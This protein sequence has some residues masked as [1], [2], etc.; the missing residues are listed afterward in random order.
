[1]TESGAGWPSTERVSPSRKESALARRYA[2]LLFGLGVVIAVQGMLQAATG[3]GKLY[4]LR[5]TSI[6]GLFGPYY[7]RDH[8]AN[9]FLMAMA[10]G[11][12]VL[13]SKMRGWAEV[14]GPSSE[15]SRELVRLAVGVM[16]LMAGIAVSGS[17][18]ALLAIP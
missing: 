12:G 5:P 17:R 8:A 10:M 3:G 9:F 2:R 18:G 7:N 6:P 14:D 16:L 13:C 11:I 15:Q 4:W 1:M